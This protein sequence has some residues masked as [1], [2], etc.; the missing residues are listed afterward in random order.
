MARKFL[1]G[2]HTQSELVD[3]WSISRS[4]RAAVGYL[5]VCARIPSLLML[6]QAHAL[7]LR[8][9][10]AASRNMILAQRGSANVYELAKQ[11]T[12]HT[13]TT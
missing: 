4:L 8:D 13:K 5:L 7:D 6:I 3:D 2:R 10:Q 1:R 11:K 9:L 12:A